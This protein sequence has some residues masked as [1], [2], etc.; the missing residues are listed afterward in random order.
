MSFLTAKELHCDGCGEWMRLAHGA[1]SHE[2]PGLKKEGWTRAGGRHYCPRC[3]LHG[4][5]EN[6]EIEIFTPHPHEK[7]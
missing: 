2:W 7:Q 1:L 4:S 3:G 6:H 5:W